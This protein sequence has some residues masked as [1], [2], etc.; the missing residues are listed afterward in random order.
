MLSER[1]FL[2]KNKLEE[3]YKKLLNQKNEEDIYK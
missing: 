2:D 3:N 1:K